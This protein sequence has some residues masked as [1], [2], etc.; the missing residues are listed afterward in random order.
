MKRVSDIGSKWSQVGLSW[1]NAVGTY[2]RRKPLGTIGAVCLLVMI[3]MALAAPWLATH[4]PNKMSAAN[5]FKSPEAHHWLGTDNYGRDLYSRIVYGSRVSLY[6]G[7]ISV[8]V[9]SGIGAI[10]GIT[11]GYSLGK[12]DLVIQRVVDIVLAFPPLLLAM[13]ISCSLGSSLNTVVLAIAIPMAAGVCRIMRS[14]AISI[15][16]YTYID[17]ARSIGCS[18]TRILARH[19][20]P[21]CIA[22]LTVI[23]TAQLSNAILTE[24]ALSFLGFGVPPPHPSWGRML[25][26]ESLQYIRRAPWLLIAPGVALSLAVYGFNLVGDAVRDLLDPM[27][28]GR[29]S[30]R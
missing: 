10:L 6:V 5:V 7:F 27:E 29:G 8:A 11:G 18:Q 28:R 14:Q 22:V 30:Q 12:V 24:A 1:L 23:A 13:V 2:A 17:A 9:G 20:A 25:A 19:V 4:D 16:E 15:R 3:V 21:N 26:A